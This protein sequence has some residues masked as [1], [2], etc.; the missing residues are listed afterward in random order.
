MGKVDAGSVDRILDRV[1][2]D[3]KPSD[4]EIADITYRVN[5][6][7]EILASIVPK[8][9][10][11]R[12]A[13]SMARGTNL[14]GTAD[15]DIFMLFDKKTD[16]DK[17]V[18]Q[19]LEYGK[20]VL[21]GR[22]GR[23]E[24]KY[25]EHP[26][27]R[28]YLDSL[29]IKADIVPAFKIDNISQMGTTVDRT[30]LHTEFIN[31]HLSKRQRDE[32]RLLKYLLKAHGIYGAEV[33]TNG[34]SGYLCELLIHNYGSLMGFLQAAS[35]F[36][37][38][39]LIEPK[40]KKES[41]GTVA[42]KKFN[43]QFVVIDP[44]DPDRN[45]AA[46]VSLESLGRLVIIARE[47]VQKPDIKLFYGHGFSDS[48]AKKIVDNLSKKAGLDT[49][50]I[51]SKIPDKSEDVIYP[52]LKKVS[53]QIL[54]HL[55]QNGFNAY[56]ITQFI[57]GKEGII[58]IAAPKQLLKSRMI[59]GPSAFIP[60]ATGAFMKKHSKS[61]GFVMDNTDLYSLENTEVATVE[62]ALRKLPEAALIHKDINLKNAKIL[63]NK[64]APDHAILLYAELQRKIFI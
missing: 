59:K 24:V 16:R 43:S 52:Q 1:L 13:G 22:K 21:K 8:N 34:F 33:K 37:L 48:N 45:V 56:F 38:P 19:G 6:L 58:F 42:S 23:F 15:V 40:S 41:E 30:P 32:V 64:V 57:S 18:K 9:V 28:L 46:G 39:V 20:A 25:A 3:I 36:K 51:V 7:M 44:V 53:G 4:A 27:L 26:Y 62:E 55:Q 2:K 49:F 47:F 12:I 17:A 5:E 35:K 11:L 29:G 31:S 10:T 50:L 60:G 63:V 61:L 14:K 54:R